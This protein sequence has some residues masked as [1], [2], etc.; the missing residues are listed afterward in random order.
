[1]YSE[2]RWAYELR[3]FFLVWR[4]L[5]PGEESWVRFEDEFTLRCDLLNMNIGLLTLVR[6]DPASL[7]QVSFA[8]RGKN[9]HVYALDERR[10]HTLRD[11]LGM[12]PARTLISCRTSCDVVPAKRKAG[13][14]VKAV[15]LLNASF[16]LH[17]LYAYNVAVGASP[18]CSDFGVCE[19]MGASR[20]FL[21]LCAPNS[22]D[23]Q[24][25]PQCAQLP[26]ARCATRRG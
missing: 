2:L 4:V 24:H 9:V 5:I 17:L 13:A 15:Y 7:Q 26:Y 10:F 6:I 18:T 3:E 25:R 19:D 12:S 8:Y 21:V 1:M 14:V 22:F 16:D 11:L 23:L 20:F